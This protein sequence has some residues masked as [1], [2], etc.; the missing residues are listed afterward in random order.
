MRPAE[1]W[2]LVIASGCLSVLLGIM[3]LAGLAN[4]A[5]IAL[6]GTLVGLN[7]IFAGSAMMAVGIARQRKDAAD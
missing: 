3:V 7:F 2:G 6:I 4:G 1:R 5:S